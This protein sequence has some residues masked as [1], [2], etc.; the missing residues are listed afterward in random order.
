VSAVRHALIELALL[1]QLRHDCDYAGAVSVSAPLLRGLRGACAGPDVN[2]WRLGTEADA[3]DP[4]RAA[5]IAAA[6]DLSAMQVNSRLVFFH[7]DTA[8]AYGSLRGR[9]SDA[10][11][12]LRIA[13]R[14]A[15]QHVHSSPL[16]RET[17]R[18][19]LDRVHRRAAGS[20]LRGLCERM[21]V[22]R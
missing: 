19:L 1:R 14:V 11:R 5:S 3:G 13:E 7:T 15:P 18:A 17:T 12:H 4:G 6:T 9:D 20:A 2:L 10:V 8:R 16:V 21:Q 22:A